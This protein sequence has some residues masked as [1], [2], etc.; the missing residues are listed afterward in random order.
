MG[1]LLQTARGLLGRGVAPAVLVAF[2]VSRSR[3]IGELVGEGTLAQ[4]GALLRQPEAIALPL[5][6]ALLLEAH[7]ERTECLR[8]HRQESGE[9][10][11]RGSLGETLGTH[12]VHRLQ[13][14]F[15][16]L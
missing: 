15:S 5:E 12:P 2:A 7:H 4:L 8:R 3:E 6:V 1:S 11:G 16:N 14:L 13:Y 10:R 9:L